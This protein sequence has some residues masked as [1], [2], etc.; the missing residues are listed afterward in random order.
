MKKIVKK[1]LFVGCT[2]IIAVTATKM[3][4]Y[5]ENQGGQVTVPA[6]VTFEE[7]TVQSSEKKTEK[8]ATSKDKPKGILPKTGE[9][10]ESY[11]FLGMMF[12]ATSILILKNKGGDVNAK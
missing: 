12:L 2:I 10:T 7:Q 11:Y 6:T 3:V 8:P 5:A 9:Y 4:T 1:I